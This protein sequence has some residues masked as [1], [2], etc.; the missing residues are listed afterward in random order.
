MLVPLAKGVMMKI[1][2]WQVWMLSAMLLWCISLT[3]FA[4]QLG[5]MDVQSALGEPLR[6]DIELIDEGSD[7]DLESLVAMV[8]VDAAYG[9]G[10]T[11]P[12]SVDA[13]EEKLFR[14]DGRF[15]ISTR[16]AHHQNGKPLLRLS[17]TDPVLIRYLEFTVQVN[18]NNQML[19]REYALLLDPWNVP[20]SNSNFVAAEVEPMPPP[21]ATNVSHDLLGASDTKDNEEETVITVETET[22]DSLNAIAKALLPELD[23]KNIT[24]E[25]LMVALFESN[26]DAFEQGNMNQ[27][28]ANQTLTV[29]ALGEVKDI[30]VA[31]D[32]VQLHASNWRAYSNQLAQLTQQMPTVQSPSV[33]H[34]HAKKIT[35][36][37]IEKSAKAVNVVKITAT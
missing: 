6:A 33:D 9:D 27:L 1:A 34:K 23:A 35:Q 11:L 3:S 37:G 29:P 16:V 10:E 5:K 8:S 12:L 18:H 32:M 19:K 2:K 30:Q 22:G 28:K 15:P 17:S 20:S 7:G 26:R 31:Y 21:P 13:Q 36:A 24:L 4:L 14:A 25:Q